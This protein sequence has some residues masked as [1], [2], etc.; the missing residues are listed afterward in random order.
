MNYSLDSNYAG[1]W[2]YVNLPGDQKDGRWVNSDTM[3]R[4]GPVFNSETV[5]YDPADYP[6]QDE[7]GEDIFL[8]GVW[9]D[10]YGNWRRRPSEWLN[11][12]GRFQKGRPAFKMPARRWF[13]NDGSYK[14]LVENKYEA[15]AFDHA[16]YNALLYRPGGVESRQAKREFHKTALAK[17]YRPGGSRAKKARKRFRKTRRKVQ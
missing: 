10:Q 1:M 13:D 12:E 3:G 17:Y 6:Y 11:A 8:E 7:S 2:D 4:S 16:A 15:H 9:K 14:D 5:G